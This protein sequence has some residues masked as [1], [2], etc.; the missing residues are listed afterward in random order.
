MKILLS[1][2]TIFFGNE[3]FF[4]ELKYSIRKK[5]VMK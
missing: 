4:L 1:E 5:K 3:C 2:N